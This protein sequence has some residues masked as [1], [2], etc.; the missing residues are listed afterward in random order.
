[1]PTAIHEMSNA[2]ASLAYPVS[3]STDEWRVT[4]AAESMNYGAYLLRKFCTGAGLSPL[5]SEW[6]HFND[7]EAITQDILN[8]AMGE[9]VPSVCLSVVPA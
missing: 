7:N 9:F 2:A 4:P 5:A 1:M 3:P 8:R 6:W